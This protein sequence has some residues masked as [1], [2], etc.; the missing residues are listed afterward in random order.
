MSAWKLW[1]GDWIFDPNFSFSTINQRLIRKSWSLAHSS[2]RLI[3]Q[4]LPHIYTSPTACAVIMNGRRFNRRLMMRRSVQTKFGCEEEEDGRR[5][6][7]GWSKTNDMHAIPFGTDINSGIACLSLGRFFFHLL[8]RARERWLMLGQG[9]MV[10]DHHLF[11]HHHSTK[12]W[13]NR[14]R[15]Y[16]IWTTGRS[17]ALKWRW[18]RKLHQRCIKKNQ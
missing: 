10:F 13:R 14:G 11:F 8:P 16:W 7:N 12:G 17:S 5:R 3:F 15:G 6:P 1:A 2:L 4:V 9:H 18:V